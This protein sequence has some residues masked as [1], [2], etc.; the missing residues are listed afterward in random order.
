MGKRRLILPPMQN[1]NKIDP[2]FKLKTYDHVKKYF[3]VICLL[4]EGD[5]FGVGEDFTKM[6][7]LSVNKVGKSCTLLSCIVI[8]LRTFNFCK[9]GHAGLG[10]AVPDPFPFLYGRVEH[11]LQFC[12][13][14]TADKS[15]AGSQYSSPYIMYLSSIVLR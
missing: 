2:V 6:S 3:L 5:Y 1:N 12:H 7:I 9:T 13:K 15:A 4:G 10:A 14:K 8:Y 11:V